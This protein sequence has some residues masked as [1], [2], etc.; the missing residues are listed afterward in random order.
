M[1]IPAVVGGLNQISAAAAISRIH[2]EQKRE[3]I[4]KENEKFI[5]IYKI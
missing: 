2:Q 1:A 5:K 4:Q 3:R